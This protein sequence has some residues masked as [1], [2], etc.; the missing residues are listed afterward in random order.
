LAPPAATEREQPAA[1]VLLA[2]DSPDNQRLIELVLK[3]SAI[4]VEIVENGQEAVDKVLALTRSGAP[5]D[6]ILMDMQMPVL[7]GYSATR[8]LR[9]QGCTAPIVALTAHAMKGDREK[10]LEAGCDEYM[11]K[12]LDVEALI[13]RILDYAEQRQATV[14]HSEK[15]G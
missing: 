9:Q 12:P 1:R 14:A 15:N 6:V 13:K 7:D 2:E 3:N 4:D 5:P 8:R 10:C 11:T